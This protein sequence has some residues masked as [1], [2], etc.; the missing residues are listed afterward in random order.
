MGQGLEEIVGKRIDAFVHP[1]PPETFAEHWERMIAAGMT[2][3]S[4]VAIVRPDGSRIWIDV[5]ASLV[6]VGDTNLVH[7]ICH[8]ITERMRLE[9]QLKRAHRMR[10]A[11][12]AEN[13][14]EHLLFIDRETHQVIEANAAA[15]D[16]YGYTAEEIT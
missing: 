1:A 5:A 4:S 2:R 10:Y 8:D 11:L 9:S 16:A 13:T 15:L 12:L 6:L 14:R 7:V 3:I